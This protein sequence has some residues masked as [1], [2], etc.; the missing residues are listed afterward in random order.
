MSERVLV[1]PAKMI[2]LPDFITGVVS[3]PTVVQKYCNAILGDGQLFFMDRKEAENN[4][5]FKQ[6]IPYVVLQKGNSTFR[7][8]RTNKGNENRLHN[9][10]SVGVGGHINP[11]DIHADNEEFMYETGFYRELAEET[12]LLFK[13]DICKKTIRA[14]LYDNS[15]N[16]GR[17]HFGVVHVVDIGDKEINLEKDKLTNGEFVHI[18]THRLEVAK[19]ENWSKLVIDNLL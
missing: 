13:S 7:Y 6:L 16:V 17:V 11:C 9:K 5:A 1:F 10:W 4:P 3:K 12:G 19:Y 18:M 14:L 2:S 8:Q 15:D